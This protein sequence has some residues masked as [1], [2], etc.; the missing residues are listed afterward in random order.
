MSLSRATIL[1]AVAFMVGVGVFSVA[2]LKW[3][4]IGMLV[5]GVVIFGVMGARVNVK[6]FA[7]IFIVV[8]ALAAGLIWATVYRPEPKQEKSFWLVARAALTAKVNKIMPQP[9]AAVFNGMV[10]GYDKNIPASLKE[11]YNITGTRHILAISGMN[12]SIVSLMLMNLGLAIGLWRRQA[13]WLALGGIIAFVL[14]VGS[15]P[16]AVRAGL[17]AGIV[18]WA[19]NRG[20]LFLAWRPLVLAAFFMVLLNPRL[21]IFDI[22]FQLSFL[23]VAGILYFKN[24]WD[25][26]FG[27]LPIKLARELLS[28]SFSA[29]ITTWPIIL[30]NFGTFS[31]IGPVANIF[32]VPFLNPIMLLGL[33]FAVF[34]WW[35]VLAKMFLWPAWLILKLADKA[36]EFFAAFPWASLNLGKPGLIVLIY[37][38]FL[39]WLW[40]FLE[41]KHLNDSA[42]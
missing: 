34:W 36:V 21:L 15:P 28:L 22:G 19:R 25:R 30:Y 8:L 26:V 16:S 18:L 13:F 32:V 39:F 33:G 6:S 40:K 12:I 31:L 4:L 5:G 9:E 11:S 35:P 17:M 7:S 38:P 10:L 24:F 41:K 1:A 37:Y 27:W 23:A 3:W 42:H 2:G 20:R 29:Q 14:L